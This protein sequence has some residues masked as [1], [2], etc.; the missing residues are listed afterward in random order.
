MLYIFYIHMRIGEI[1]EASGTQ[2]AAVTH[3]NYNTICR[4]PNSLIGRLTSLHG[5]A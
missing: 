3:W 1:G 5:K 4:G 2:I